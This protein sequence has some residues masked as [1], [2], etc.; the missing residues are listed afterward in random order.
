[1]RQEIITMRDVKIIGIAKEMAFSKGPEECPKFW[2]EFFQKYVKP[3][4]EGTA[5]DAVQKAVFDNHIGQYAVCDC[6]RKVRNCS[7]CGEEALAECGGKFRYIIAGEYEGGKVPEGMSIIILPD[8]EWLKFHF[9]GGMPAFQEQYK[10]VF[11]DWLPNHKEIAGNPDM[12]IEWYEGD[13]LTSPDFKCGI[14]LH[15]K[16]Q[17]MYNPAL[18][19]LIL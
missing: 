17:D 8:G 18:G 5:P 4:I 11:N 6:N 1:M 10:A 19:S 15:I 7:N 9:D 13:D 12:L 2:G 3:V 16:R 14:M